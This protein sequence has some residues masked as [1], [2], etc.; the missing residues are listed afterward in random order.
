MRCELKEKIK[1]ALKCWRRLAT[2]H[3]ID[4]LNEYS[5]TCSDNHFQANIAMEYTLLLNQN[6]TLSLSIS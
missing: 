3:L 6:K 2:F 1:L 5:F 4:Y